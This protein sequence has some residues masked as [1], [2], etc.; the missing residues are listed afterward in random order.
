MHIKGFTHEMV[1]N[2]VNYYYSKKIIA[3]WLE[4]GEITE[5]EFK[6][7]DKMNRISFNSHLK[8]LMWI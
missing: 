4:M 2:E 7:L 5:Q 3:R 8:D 1:I 6:E